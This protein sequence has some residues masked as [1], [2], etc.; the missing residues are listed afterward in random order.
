MP[1]ISKNDRSKSRNRLKIFRHVR[2]I[3]QEDEAALINVVVLRKR[4][5]ENAC[6]EEEPPP[7]ISKVLRSWAIQSYIK[8]RAL[9]ALLKILVCFGLKTLPRDSRTLL[10]TPRFVEIE[11]RAHGDFWYN[12]M[13]N[14][15][16]NIFAKLTT[17]MK[18]EL[19]FNVD[20]IPL[21]KSSPITFWPIL[22]NIHG[23]PDIKPMIVAIWSGIGKLDNIN[24]L[25]EP[26]VADIN[27]S[28]LNGIVI[29]DRRIDISV[30]SFLSDSPLANR[31][32]DP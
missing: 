8:Q 12:G 23:M 18:I 6:N 9:S 20:G 16:E 3:M 4:M 19:N 29:N 11:K 21:F 25:L 17:D 24:D 27:R 32:R 31:Q 2:A 14:C 7:T 26:L 28:V 1:K 15:L 10:K 13:S 30:R 5:F 22:A